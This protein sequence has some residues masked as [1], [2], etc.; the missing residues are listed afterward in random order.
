MDDDGRMLVYATEIVGP[1]GKT[2][3]QEFTFEVG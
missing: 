3:S 1:K 2:Q